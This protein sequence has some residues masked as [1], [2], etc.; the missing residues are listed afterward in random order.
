MPDAL[1]V[2]HGQP[3]DPE[4]ASAALAVFARRV[5]AHEN[6]SLA[7]ATLANP[8]ELEAALTSLPTQA[9]IYPLFMAKGWFVTD[10]L[11]RRMG[12]HPHP[13]LNPLGIDPDLPGLAAAAVADAAQR[14][15]WDLAST[16]VILAAHGS[17]RSRNPSAVAREFAQALLAHS[18][19]Q[20]LHLGFVEERPGIAEAAA[21]AAPRSICLPFFACQG[22]HANE[23][24]P[25]ALKTAGFKGVLLPVIG[26]L[27][28]VERQIAGHI[29]RQLAE[30]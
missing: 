4:S 12:Q 19:A 6:L 28:Q 17:G 13:I 10:A 21:Q 18:G 8:G 1:I 5:E 2:A 14:E 23:D 20:A 3:S 11:P 15:G 27:P 26:A 22:G 25:Q 9:P 24:V 7:S 16:D 30:R 29:R